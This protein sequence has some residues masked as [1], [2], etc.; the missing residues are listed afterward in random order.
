MRLSAFEDTSSSRRSRAD[1]SCCGCIRREEIE[2]YNSRDEEGGNQCG[3]KK[4]E[5]V[6]EVLTEDLSSEVFDD[7]DSSVSRS[8]AI[9][10]G[11]KRWQLMTKDEQN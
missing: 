5:E 11:T 1:S 2:K 7:K 10:R 3:K 8:C 9:E 4:K 6:I